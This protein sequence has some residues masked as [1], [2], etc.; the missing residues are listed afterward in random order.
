MSAEELKTA[1]RQYADEHLP[2]WAVVG[3]SFR[4]GDVGAHVTET[5]VVLASP[6]GAS[7]PRETE[8]APSLAR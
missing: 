5:L 4:M 6:P 3:I 2:G 7:P 8:R 1:A